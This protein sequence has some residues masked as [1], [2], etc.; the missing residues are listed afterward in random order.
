MMDHQ[1]QCKGSTSYNYK[2][3]AEEK[4][5]EVKVSKPGMPYEDQQLLIYVRNK[6]E[7]G[8]VCPLHIFTNFSSWLRHLIKLRCTTHRLECPFLHEDLSDCKVNKK[9]AMYV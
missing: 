5:K 6:M 4:E 3:R 1:A 2:K 7:S 8:C 9:L